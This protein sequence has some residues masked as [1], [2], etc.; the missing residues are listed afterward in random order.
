MNSIEDV[1]KKESGTN[2]HQKKYLLNDNISLLISKKRKEKFEP[3][4]SADDKLLEYGVGGGFN[5]RLIDCKEKVGF[6]IAESV[7]EQIAQLNINFKSAIDDIPDSY[8]D[9]VI[10]NHVLEHVHSPID[11]LVIIKAKMKAEGKLLLTVPYEHKKKFLKY[12]GEDEDFHLF[13][14][15]VQTLTY[16]TKSL[17]FTCIKTEVRP[18]GFDRY[19]AHLIKKWKLPDTFFNSIYKVLNFLRPT[20]EIFLVLKN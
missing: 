4:I 14:W 18:Y 12:N 5:I 10:C 9:V 2:Y 6:D 13:A 15:N 1:Y 11:T 8:F 7:R 17:G 20:K 19:T 3:F 16:M